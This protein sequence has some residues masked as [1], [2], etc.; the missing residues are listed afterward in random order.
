MKKPIPVGENCWIEAEDISAVL[1]QNGSLLV[2]LKS[3]KTVN[4]SDDMTREELEN[5]IEA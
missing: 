1:R 2:F 3:G 5:L 4:V